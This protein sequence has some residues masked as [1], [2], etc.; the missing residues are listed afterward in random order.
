MTTAQQ[1]LDFY[2]NLSLKSV[3]EPG[4]S[5]MNPFL[6]EEVQEVNSVFYN[7]FFNDESKRFFLIAI[8]PGR[9]GAGVSG[10]PFTDPVVLEDVL[11]ISNSFQKRKE[12]SAVFV[13]ELIEAM[14]G[15]EAFYN[16]FFIT[17][18][19]PL[20]FMKDGKNLNYYDIAS[21]QNEL[22]PFIIET[23]N[24]Q[25]EKWGRT[26]IAFT[27]GK[28]TNHKAMVKL[29]NEYKWFE[30]IVALP[31]PR[32]VMQYRL[33]FKDQLIDEVKSTI[34]EEISKS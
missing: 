25:V 11:H 27:I 22:K 26:E 5:V 10:I 9:F 30:K 31:H 16:Q 33:R 18:V 15:P 21:L 1:I 14:G 3:K 2:S 12:L 29:N 24:H 28:G 4:V 8:N 20:G 23:M 17:N 6:S 34:L 13:Y 7:R 19:S 32:W